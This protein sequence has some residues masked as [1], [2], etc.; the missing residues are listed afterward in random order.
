[1]PETGTSARN[2]S[3]LELT[4][5]TNQIAKDV[6]DFHVLDSEVDFT[7][8]N[9]ILEEERAKSIDVLKAML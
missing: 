6:N 8:A 9:R 5:L 1:M 7:E 2:I 4:G 3:L